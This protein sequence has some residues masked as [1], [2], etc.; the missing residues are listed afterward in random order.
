M[1]DPV[2]VKRRLALTLYY[3]SE[4]AE[5]RTVANLFG[6]SRSFVCQCIREVSLTMIKCLPK[7]ITFPKGPFTKDVRG[8]GGRGVAGIWTNSDIGRRVLP[9]NPDVRV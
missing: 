9:N 6:V 4:T 2:T 3:L 5:Y 1:R 8:E 7:V